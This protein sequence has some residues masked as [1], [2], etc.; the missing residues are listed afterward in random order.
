[1]SENAK[2][3]GETLGP[4]HLFPSDREGELSE[5]DAYEAVLGSLESEDEESEEQSGPGEPPAPE[6]EEDE[7]AGS[8]DEA[9]TEAETEDDESEEDVES[10][11]D[12]DDEEPEYYPVKVDGE[13]WEV[14][15]EEA[16][17][18][19]MRQEDYTRKR[20]AEA[21]EHRERLAEVGKKADEYMQRL[22]VLDAA[23]RDQHPSLQR[24]PEE[25]Q[26]LRAEDPA[27]FN[28]EY[29]DAQLAHQRLQAVY[30]EVD[31][32]RQ[33]QAERFDAQFQEHLKQEGKALREALGWRSDEEANEGLRTLE[34]YAKSTY[35][36]TD[37]ELAGVA[38]HRL[39]VLLEKARKYDE[40]QT[41]GQARIRKK[42]ASK[43]KLK[44]G[45]RKKRSGKGLKRARRIK[46]VQE[47]LARTGSEEAALALISE[48]L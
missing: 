24:T 28:E 21:Q 29:A 35:N 48:T 19:Y 13:E 17:D 2:K 30:Q 6:S 40:G 20:Q 42:V 38:D 25:W 46:K 37:E 3:D 47:E 36:F 9:E 44:P 26:K 7:E 5:Q 11:E 27:R 23:I 4:E 34:Q 18:G 45:S 31:R 41:E 15:L 8:E 22:E 32:V 16:L 43:G 39:M 1:M 10:G 12:A 14:T 33:E